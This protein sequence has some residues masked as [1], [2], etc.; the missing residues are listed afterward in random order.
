MIP[1]RGDPRAILAAAV[2]ECATNVRK[3]ADGDTLTVTTSETDGLV[4]MTLIGNGNS[5]TKPV[6]ESGGLASLRRLTEQAGGTMEITAASDF[7]L[8]IHVPA[9]GL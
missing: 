9:A 7:T 3:H 4:S 2:S 6:T 5:V 1:E 8:T